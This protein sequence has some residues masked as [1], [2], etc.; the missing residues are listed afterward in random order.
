MIHSVLTIIAARRG[1]AEGRATEIP[2]G[3]GARTLVSHQSQG[4]S[5][6]VIGNPSE[7]ILAF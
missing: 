5:W 7:I 3:R 4:F 1:H 2:Y 6:P